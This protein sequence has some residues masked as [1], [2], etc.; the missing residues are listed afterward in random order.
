MQQFDITLFFITVFL[1]GIF[2]FLIVLGVVYFYLGKGERKDR[3]TL[4]FCKQ[5]KATRLRLTRWN[6]C[7]G[8]YSIKKRLK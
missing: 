6:K 3:S 2:L 7:L 8:R 5:V 1:F 4:C